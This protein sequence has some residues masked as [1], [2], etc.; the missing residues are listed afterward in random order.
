[1]FR[2]VFGGTKHH[3]RLFSAL[4]A[5]QGAQEIQPVHDGHIPIEQDGVRHLLTAMIEG[6][7][8]IGRF[9][10]IKFKIAN[11]ASGDFAHNARVINNKAALHRCVP[12]DYTTYG[13]NYTG[14]SVNKVLPK[15]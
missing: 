1:M 2:V 14:V 12:T 8:A 5:A 13:C 15:A 7:G 9:Q 11:N 10:D 3:D 4:L 6:F